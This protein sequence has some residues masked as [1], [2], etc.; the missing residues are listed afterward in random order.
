MM[1]IVLTEYE[2]EIGNGRQYCIVDI[3][4]RVERWSMD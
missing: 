2:Y 4:W 1:Y 3:E